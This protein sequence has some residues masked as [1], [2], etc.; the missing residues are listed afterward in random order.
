MEI[1]CVLYTHRE[2]EGRE[3]GATMQGTERERKVNNKKQQQA[4]SNVDGKEE[5]H[6]TEI[7]QYV[8]HS[9]PRCACAPLCVCVCNVYLVESYFMENSNNSTDFFPT[10]MGCESCA[11]H[12]Y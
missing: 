1:F 5:T 9:Y 12:D 10:R 7:I 6:T 11:L 2:M 8:C 3:R 4:C